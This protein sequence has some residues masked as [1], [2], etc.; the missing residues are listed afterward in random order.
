MSKG[1]DWLSMAMSLKDKWVEGSNSGIDGAVNS[2]D[3]R[4]PKKARQQAAFNMTASGLAG[5]SHA[6]NSLTRT[7]GVLG[8]LGH[9]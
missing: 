9:D 8:N 2:A 3:L 5:E 7:G 4:K 1:A 6:L